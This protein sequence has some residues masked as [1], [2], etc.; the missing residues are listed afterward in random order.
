MRKRAA[1]TTRGRRSRQLNGA[2]V[3]QYKIPAEQRVSAQRLEEPGVTAESAKRICASNFWKNNTRRN[4]EKK[5]GTTT[6]R[7]CTMVQ[8]I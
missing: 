2:G 6:N 3:L 4:T 5:K 1:V 8:W 7:L